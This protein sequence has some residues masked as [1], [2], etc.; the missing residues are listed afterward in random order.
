MKLVVTVVGKDRVGITAGV[1]RVL[2]ENNINI[3]SINQTILEDIFNMIMMCE[4]AD[5]ADLSAIQQALRE[6]GESLGVQVLV[7]NAAIFLSMHRVG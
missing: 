2:A 3:V 6:E 4:V 5:S 7:Q 1:T